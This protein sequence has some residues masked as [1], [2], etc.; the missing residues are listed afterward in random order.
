M[1]AEFSTPNLVKSADPGPRLKA[2]FG[3]GNCLSGLSG[4]KVIALAVKSRQCLPNADLTR[5]AK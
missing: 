1:C 4:F 3:R 2:V 5:N